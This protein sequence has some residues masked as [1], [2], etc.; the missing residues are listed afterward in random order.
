[1]H[2]DGVHG[3]GE[4]DECELDIQKLT[5][6]P[7]NKLLEVLHPIWID[8]NIPLLEKTAELEK[9]FN[10]FL[11]GGSIEKT[12][13]EKSDQQATKSIMPAPEG[14]KWEEVKIRITE[15]GKISLKVKGIERTYSSEDFIK[16]IKLKNYLKEIFLKTLHAQHGIIE[17]NE[18]KNFKQNISDLRRVF[19]D[20]F[21]I[22]DDPIP[23]HE[24]KTYKAKF[25][26][27]SDLGKSSSTNN[28]L[29]P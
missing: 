24:A 5:N 9:A 19:K 25:L 12:I 18:S 1:M 27:Q 16:L 10:K 8:K 15:E 22:T 3:Y 28:D 2:I 26:T 11:Y 20:A 4:C 14:T 6:T 21:G 23:S 17:E 29:S 7:Y 13:K